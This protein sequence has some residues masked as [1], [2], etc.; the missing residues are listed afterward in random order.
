MNGSIMEAGEGRMDADEKAGGR[1][2]GRC[3]RRHRAGAGE[4]G[5]R[6]PASTGRAMP[7]LRLSLVTLGV[8]DL[9]RAVTFYEA[10]GLKRRVKEAAGAAFFD[11]GGAVLS[12]YPRHELAADAGVL[13]GRAGAFGGIALACNRAS[14]AEVDT[15][16]IRAVAAGG[17]ALRPAQPTFWGGYSG[18]VADPDGHPWEI[19]HNPGFPFDAA[20]RI[21]LPE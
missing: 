19:A 7:P 16:L 20:G 14:R 6:E 13:P 11:A 1:D 3:R 15:T 4:A 17:R 9:Q 10:L 2:A 21:V 18:Y 5:P 8:A 12:L